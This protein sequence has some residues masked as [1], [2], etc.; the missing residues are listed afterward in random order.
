MD[1]NVLV[2]NNLVPAG[3]EPATNNT[4]RPHAAG[5]VLCAVLISREDNW[6]ELLDSIPAADLRRNVAAAVLAIREALRLEADHALDL[7][8]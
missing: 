4:R 1:C 3:L 2:I 5:D 6:E 7:C 8:R